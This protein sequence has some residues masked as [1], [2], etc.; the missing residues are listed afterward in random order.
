MKPECMLFVSLHSCF[1]KLHQA[2]LSG[3]TVNAKN[4]E[5]KKIL[6]TVKRCLSIVNEDYEEDY[7]Q[8]RYYLLKESLNNKPGTRDSVFPQ[9]CFSCSC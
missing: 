6:Q 9:L 4:K 1:A 8:V 5:N 7:E 3:G 2:R